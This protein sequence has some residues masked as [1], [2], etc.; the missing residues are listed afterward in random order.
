MER[1]QDAR[2]MPQKDIGPGSHCRNQ[3]QPGSVT[4]SKEQDDAPLTLIIAI[5]AFKD[6]T[7]LFSLSNLNYS[8]KRCQWHR[9]Y[10]K[11]MTTQLNW[12]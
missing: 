9:G 10:P 6:S 2:W 4:V 1:Q 5:S 7:D 12:L 8:R 3:Y 11:A